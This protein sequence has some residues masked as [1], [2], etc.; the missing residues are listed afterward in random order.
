[1]KM[2]RILVRAALVVTFTVTA[3]LALDRI[4][5]PNLTRYLDRSTEVVDANGR[6]LRAFTTS[7]GQWRLKTTV[8][9]VDPTYLALLKSYEDSRFDYHFGVD[10]LSIVRAT[11]Q[12]I[13]RGHIVSGAST[14]TMQAARLL[15]PRPRTFAAKA[16]E[17]ARAIQ[18]EWHFSKREVMGIYLTLAPMGG[19]LE[20]LRAASLAYFGKE[21]KQLN[22][23]EAALLVAIP[24][25]PTR[26][27]PDHSPPAAQ[28]GRDGVLARGLEDGVLDQKLY[29][30]AMSRPVP[31]VR[32]ALP[33]NAPHLAAWL[34]PQSPG[35][36]IPTTIR[37]QLQSSLAQLVAEERGQMSDRAQVA[38]VVMDNRTGGVVAWLAGGDFFGHAGQVDLVR[39]HRSP[40][41]ALKPLIYALAFDDR[42]LHP[43]SIVEDVPV[44]FK[45][46]LPH[47]FDREHLG[48]V[49]VRRALQQSLNIPAVLALERVGPARFL[50]TLRAAGAAPGLPSGDP[51]NSLGMALGS[52]TVSPLEMAGLYCGLANGGRFAPPQIRRDQPKTEPVQLLGDAAAWYVGDILAEAPLPDGFASLPVAMRDRRIAYK[53]GTSAGFRD[54][55]AAGYS[56]NWTVVVWVGHADGTP[57]PGQL[58]RAAALPILLKAFGRLPGEDNHAPRTP[59]DV[60]KVGSWKELPLRMQRLGLTAVEGAPRIAYPP[61]DARLELDQHDSVTLAA[62]GSGKLHWLVNGRPL[63]GN[64]WTPDSA[65]LMRLAVVDDAGRASAV[66]VRIVRRP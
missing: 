23:A 1:M 45:D 21:P 48:E 62:S 7:D 49:T 63:A 26:R 17:A 56:A 41:S 25:S 61:P 8:D 5:P 53:T 57:R 12:D 24:Q 32:L 55:W 18:L 36:I 64:T 16:I 35:A 22:A 9:D 34:A 4:F 40:G 51:G 20:G 15:E 31:T 44:R 42:T 47:N 6:L 59:A 14:L 33:M 58:G 50:S 39:A 46:W 52:A 28:A 19:N 3:A 54:A 2:Q 10:P 43:E 13:A 11:V 65:G 66:T 29:A 37:L 30:A 38:M 27:R 60:I